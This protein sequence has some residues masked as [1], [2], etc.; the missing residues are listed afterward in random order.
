MVMC[1]VMRFPVAESRPASN[2]SSQ[3]LPP[4]WRI[5]PVLI[6]DI[7]HIQLIFASGSS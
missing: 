7:R 5:W 4:R 3:E 2:F 6:A 1:F